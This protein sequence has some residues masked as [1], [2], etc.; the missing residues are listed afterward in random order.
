MLVPAL[1]AEGNLHVGQPL[2]V[3][4]IPWGFGQRLQERGG[5]E[6]RMKG[7]VKE[8]TQHL[9]LMMTYSSVGTLSSSMSILSCWR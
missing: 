2:L 6:E 5:R 7:R 8:A 1:H 3:R 9:T 4:V